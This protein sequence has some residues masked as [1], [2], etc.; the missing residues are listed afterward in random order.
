MCLN[1]KTQDSIQSAGDD[2]AEYT[3]RGEVR[4]N[5]TVF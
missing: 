5:A 4:A 3:H 1:Y 2:L